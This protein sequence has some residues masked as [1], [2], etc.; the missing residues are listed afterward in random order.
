MAFERIVLFRP[1]YDKRSNDPKKDYG[2]N[3]VEMLMVLKG[4]EGAVQFLLLTNWQLPH[5]NKEFEDRPPLP[6]LPPP[7]FDIPGY[8]PRF[9][10]KHLLCRP[11][12]ADLGYHSPKPMYEGQEPMGLKEIKIRKNPKKKG[13]NGYF[14]STNPKPT[15]CEWLDGKPCYYDGSGINAEPI[16]DVLLREG[17]DGVWREL[18]KY[19]HSVFSEKKADERK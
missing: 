3:G 7:V 12:P 5:I 8:R 1:A 4:P 15:P 16:F 6:D 10:M 9:S 14:T 17:S 11:M 13:M 2:I 19:Y 18:E